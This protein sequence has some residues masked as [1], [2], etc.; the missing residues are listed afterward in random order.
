MKLR[1]PSQAR[2][3]TADQIHRALVEDF[4]QGVHTPLLAFLAGIKRAAE[5]RKQDPERVYQDIRQ[6]ALALGGKGNVF[7]IPGSFN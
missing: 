3:M 7:D 5:L 1:E 2:E 6:E 4:V